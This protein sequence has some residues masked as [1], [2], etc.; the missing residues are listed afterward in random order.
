M[1]GRIR[2][3][4]AGRDGITAGPPAQD[5]APGVSPPVNGHG[6]VL[7]AAASDTL[8]RWALGCIGVVIVLALWQLTTSVWLKSEAELAPPGAVIGNLYDQIQSAQFW[9]YVWQTF[10]SWALGLAISV[11]IGI[12]LGILVGSSTIA[13]HALRPT[14]EFLR[15][16][17]GIALMPLALLLWGQSTKSDVFLIAFGTLW[18][19]VVQAMYGVR[20]VDPIALET[21][22]VFG[23]GTAARIRYIVL[24]SSLPYLA[25]GIRIASSVALVI[26]ISAELLIGDPGLGNQIGLAQSY[27]QFDEMYALILATGLLGMILQILSVGLERYFL[28]WHESQRGEATS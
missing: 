9:Q 26:A 4:G 24:P 28:R 25:T 21:G 22:R 12:P 2:L 14:L 15:P 1:S 6:G 7:G 18:T 13:W 23:L 27:S 11:V 10:S 16:I 17:P 5:P 19:L 3:A 8:Q 20:A